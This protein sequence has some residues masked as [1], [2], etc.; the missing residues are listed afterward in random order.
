MSIYN[1]IEYSDNYSR[2]YVNLW[3][4]YKMSP[5]ITQQTLNH[6]NIK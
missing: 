4:Y 3:Q 1:L 5:M 2:K 6:F